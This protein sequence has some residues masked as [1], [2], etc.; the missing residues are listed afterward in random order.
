MAGAL[1]GAAISSNYSVN[2][3]N[4]YNDRKVVYINC[5]FDSNFNH[6]DGN[7]KKLAF[8]ELRVFADKNDHLKSQTVFKFNSDLYFGGYDK[9]KGIYSFYKFND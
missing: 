7:I 9:T 8:D 2:N 1:I 6:I 4:S 3:L 5:L